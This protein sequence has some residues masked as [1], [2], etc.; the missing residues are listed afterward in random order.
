MPFSSEYSAIVISDHSPLLLDLR[1]DSPSAAPP[2]W[3]LN[4]SLL[5]DEA[6][7]TSITQAIEEFMFFNNSDETNSSLLWETLKAFLRGKIISHSAYHNRQRRKIQKDIIDQISDIET[8][9]AINPTQDLYQQKVNL[10]TQF[11]LTSTEKAERSILRSKGTLDEH[12]DKPAVCWPSNSN[13]NQHH[14]TS[15]RAM[16]N[17]TNLQ[18]VPWKSMPPLKHTFRN[19]IHQNPQKAQTWIHFSVT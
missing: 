1:L 7:C 11:D 12:G 8:Q 5:S 18:R 14:D 13:G 15:L 6:F 16:T 9:Y 17:Q 3:R 2:Q 19:C 4:T 10:Q